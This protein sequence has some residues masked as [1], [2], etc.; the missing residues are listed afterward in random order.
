[1]KTTSLQ[2]ARYLEKSGICR[3]FTVTGGGAMFL[4]RAFDEVFG[5]KV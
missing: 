4:N 5:S 1:M 3:V 2:I